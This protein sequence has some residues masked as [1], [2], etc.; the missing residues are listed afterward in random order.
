MPELNKA[1]RQVCDLDIRILSTKK[2]FLFFDTANTTTISMSAESVFAMAKGAKR[3]SFQDPMDGTLAVEAQVYPFKLFALMTDGII[4]T[5]AAYADKQTVTAAAAG[6][7]SIT[8][9][10]GGTIQTG[11]VFVYPEDRFGDEAALIAG[12]YAGGT[13]TAT[14]AAD[15]AQGEKYTVGYIITRTT[16]LKKIAFNNKRLPK[17][18]YITASTLDKDEEGVLTPFKQVFYKASVQ[19]N[20]ELAFSSEGDPATV[21]VTFDIMEDKNGNY[22][23]MIEITDEG[24]SVGKPAIRV[25]KGASSEDVAIYGA[26]DTVTAAITDGSG[27][28]YS[29]LHATISNDN[30][31]V[32]ISAD[33]DA[34]VATYTVTL[35]DSASQTASFTVTVYTAG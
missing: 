24:M 16:G 1:N 34:A 5:T 8:V 18:Y 33:A 13:F 20:F 15:I 21:T 22:V 2:P 23:D 6:A 12:T 17:D 10:S 7:V 11:T 26:V 14:T 19:R 29:K 32:I 25:A 27:T 35:T 31:T 28:T 3:V 4:D 9:P 30:D